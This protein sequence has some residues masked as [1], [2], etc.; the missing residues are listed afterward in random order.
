MKTYITKGKIM[1]LTKHRDEFN[2]KMSSDEVNKLCFLLKGY[3]S[4]VK[5]VQHLVEAP[6]V[7]GLLQEY[8]EEL[9]KYQREAY[10]YDQ[11]LE[12]QSMGSNR[13]M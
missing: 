5:E 7:M 10:A 8:L 12:E 1:Y 9:T 3:T 4:A 13:T 6:T 2:L 11:Y